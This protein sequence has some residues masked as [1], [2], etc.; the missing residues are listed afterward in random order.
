MTTATAL[1]PPAAPPAPALRLQVDLTREGLLRVLVAAGDL[2]PANA[3]LNRL[4]DAARQSVAAAAAQ[5]RGSEASTTAARLARQVE[6]ARGKHTAAVESALKAGRATAL[7]LAEGKDPRPHER[8]AAVA[9][10]NARRESGRLASLEPLAER[11]RARARVELRQAAVT[12][13]E[14]AIAALVAHRE[15]LVAALT[16]A[17]GASVVL[18][19]LA[20]DSALVRVHDAETGGIPGDWL[21]TELRPR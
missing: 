6:E 12:A 14:A 13:W 5:A 16:E 4:L 18:P 8:A 17:L 7:A 21:P 15:R 9:D 3:E 2:E 19:L 11:A 20:V 10:A 1:A